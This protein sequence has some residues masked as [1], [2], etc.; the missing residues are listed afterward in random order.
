MVKSPQ[1]E[2]LKIRKTDYPINNETPMFGTGSSQKTSKLPIN[3][4]KGSQISLTVSEMQIKA[5]MM[6]YFII[7][8]PISKNKCE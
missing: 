5:T 7:S 4:R 2:L 1:L 8:P 6:Y 3:I